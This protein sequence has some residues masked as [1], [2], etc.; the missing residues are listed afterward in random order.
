MNLQEEKKGFSLY[1][2]FGRYMGREIKPDMEHPVNSKHNAVRI[3]M[4]EIQEIS[5]DNGLRVR[6]LFGKKAEDIGV[7]PENRNRLNVIV[8]PDSRGKN[9]IAQM[10][11]G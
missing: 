8:D 11:L 5:E 2:L 6:F 9:R 3:L 4:N 10:T 1:R 7:S